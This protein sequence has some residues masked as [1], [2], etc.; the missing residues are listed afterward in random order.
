MQPPAPAQ[1]LICSPFF[2]LR[3]I[4][5]F[6]YNEPILVESLSNTNTIHKSLTG[7]D[8]S[9]AEDSFALFFSSPFQFFFCTGPP[10]SRIVYKSNW[11]EERETDCKTAEEGSQH[12]DSLTQRSPSIYLSIYL[13]IYIYV[14]IYLISIHP[15]LPHYISIYLQIYRIEFTYM[16]KA[17]TCMCLFR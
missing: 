13:S 14:Y 7:T 17:C 9:T 12:S 10:L 1:R 16:I 15:L 3:K 2:L 4:R 6:F 11:E 5:T 8:N